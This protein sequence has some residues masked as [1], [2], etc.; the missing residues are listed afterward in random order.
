M[1]PQAIPLLSH[2]VQPVI[3]VDLLVIAV[4]FVTR[5]LLFFG[6]PLDLPVLLVL[7]LPLGLASLLLPLFILPILHPL[8]VSPVPRTLGHILGKGWVEVRD[9]A[10]VPLQPPEP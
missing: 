6:L 9:Q 2:G 7:L 1:T 4:L 5:L 8:G 3:L 10:E